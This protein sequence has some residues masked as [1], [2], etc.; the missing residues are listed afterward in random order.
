MECGEKTSNKRLTLKDVFADFMSNLLE[1][2]FPLL[3]TVKGLTLRPGVLCREYING[4]RKP[5]S[6]P[7]Q[8]YLVTLAIFYLFFLALGLQI[9]DFSAGIVPEFPEGEAGA[10]ARELAGQINQ[11]INQYSRLFHFVLI[12]ITSLFSWV[13]FKKVGYNFTENFVMNLFLGGHIML[14]SMLCI[15]LWFVNFNL[16]FAVSGIVGVSYQVWGYKDFF[17]VKT[18]TAVGKGL[19]AWFL[20]MIVFS[21]LNLLVTF[22]VIRIFNTN[23]AI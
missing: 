16:Y 3:N 7:F 9:S 10:P 13:I 18:S 23:D 17:Q 14:I 1:L 15:P 21:I 19:L 12:P 4:K 22:T 5:Y 11:L 6:R 2:E 20:G 8:Y